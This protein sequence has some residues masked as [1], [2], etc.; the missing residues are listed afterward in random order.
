MLKPGYRI[1]ETHEFEGA[2]VDIIAWTELRGMTH[3]AGVQTLDHFRGAGMAV[4]QIR[5]TLKGGKDEITT[6]AGALQFLS[7]RIDMENRIPAG[8]VMRRLF[9]SALTGESVFRP[10][11]RGKGEIWLEPTLGHYVIVGLGPETVIVDQGAFHVA[12]KGVAV[13]AK[14]QGNVSSALFGG[15]GLFQTAI[16][17]P[18]F[19][20]LQ[21]PVP[22]DELIKM[23]VEPG[24]KC[25]L[26]GPFALLRT[27][28]LTFSVSKSSRT[29]IGSTTTGDGLL[30]TFENRSREAGEVWVSPLEP[31]YNQF[32]QWIHQHNASSSSGGQN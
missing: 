6:E 21:S 20:I 31:I 11:Y 23:A 10:T 9:G 1:A 22:E 14:L 24:E 13:E 32:G 5:V 28:N 12:G 3:I 26:D 30:N 17:G 16:T 29:W 15:E 25:V 4:R 8:K 27:A 2:V 18:G 19:C 7:G